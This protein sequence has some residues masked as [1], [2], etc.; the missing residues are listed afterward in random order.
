M[1]RRL[2][3]KQ[4]VD[5]FTRACRKLDAAVGLAHHT[6]SVMKFIGLTEPDP[7]R[8]F[9][10]SGPSLFCSC[11][12]ERWPFFAHTSCPNGCPWV[13]STFR[14]PAWASD[15]TLL[16]RVQKIHREAA[17]RERCETECNGAAWPMHPNEMP[18]A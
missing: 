6:L 5:A 7:W 12:G 11:C 10:E 4:A 14:A 8:T 18:R 2:S 13:F 9:F 15:E 1:S 17:A 16:K 3:T